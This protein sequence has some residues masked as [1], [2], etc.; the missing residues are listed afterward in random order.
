MKGYEKV[1]YEANSDDGSGGIVRDDGKWIAQTRSKYED[2]FVDAKTN[3]PILATA[4]DL[5]E[6]CEAAADWI[7]GL[8]YYFPGGDKQPGLDQMRAIIA[9]ARETGG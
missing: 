4:F 7:D 1:R 8:V 2:A 9:R 6:A 3:G 5:L